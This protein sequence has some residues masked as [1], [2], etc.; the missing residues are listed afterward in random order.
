M[1]ATS[2]PGRG[3]LCLSYIRSRIAITSWLRPAITVLLSRRTARPEPL[4]GG[5]AGGPH[6]VTEAAGEIR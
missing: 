5:G 1:L 6:P 3:A 2:P 4:G